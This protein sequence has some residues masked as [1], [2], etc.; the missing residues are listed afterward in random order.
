MKILLIG[1]SGMVGQGVLRECLAANDV[2]IVV[3][4]ARTPTATRHPKLLERVVPDFSKLAAIEAEL[5]G[6]SACFYCAGVSAFRMSEADYSRMTYDL[7]L[8]VARAV[9]RLNPT[10]TFVYFSGAGTD[11]S[12]R[13]RSMWARV[14]GRTEN[15]L[16][17]LPCRAYAFRPGII[18]PVDGIVSKTK[19]YRTLYALMNPLLP[20]LEAALPR[21]VTNT[22]QVGRAMLTVARVG[23]RKRILET[24]DI[25]AL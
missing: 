17:A 4:L 14:K 15:A 11:S 9:V 6:V 20:L 19:L 23:A 7:T 1:A 3:S 13:G 24:P 18:R 8:A 16:L 5:A 25:N 12:E 2:D 10:L 22:R 21:L